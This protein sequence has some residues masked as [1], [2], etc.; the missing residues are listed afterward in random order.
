MRQLTE[1]QRQFLEHEMAGVEAS[2]KLLDLVPELLQSR[3]A[4]RADD[5]L[6]IAE[7]LIGR[8]GWEIRMFK[9]AKAPDERAH[10]LAGATT[11]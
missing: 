10:I 6:V 5:K 4:L 7:L 3:N 2:R 9:F 1:E 8:A 11:D